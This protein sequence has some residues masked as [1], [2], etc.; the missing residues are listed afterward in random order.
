M[1]NLQRLVALLERERYARQ[2]TDEAVAR[3]IFEEFG[4]DAGAETVT[5]ALAPV[6]AD[7]P[8]P[9]MFPVVETAG[10]P[11]G[12]QPMPKVRAKKGE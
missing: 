5:E 3:A 4:I 6:V 10:D 12:G 9:A 8:P 11:V 1:T 7:D 2:W